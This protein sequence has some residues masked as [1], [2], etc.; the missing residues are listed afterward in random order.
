MAAHLF[1][2]PPP[3][4]SC[5]HSPQ[6]RVWAGPGVSPWRRCTP[7][8]GQGAWGAPQW[9]PCLL[10]VS[11]A[12]LCQLWAPRVRLGYL[13]SVGRALRAMSSGDLPDYP[14]HQLDPPG[15]KMACTS[16][17]MFKTRC[18]DFTSSFEL[19]AANWPPLRQDSC[20]Q[21]DPSA[22]SRRCHPKA[23]TP[24][25]VPQPHALVSEHPF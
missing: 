15:P 10:P 16:V 7:V 13:H 24:H 8:K 12:A 14:T 20:T 1:L 19:S 18:R 11:A 4:N 23:P 17:M 6:R 3:L 25:H 5:L 22:G 2:L 9:T 21:A